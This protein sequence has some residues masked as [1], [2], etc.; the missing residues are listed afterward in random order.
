MTVAE[1][2]TVVLVR[3]GARVCALPIGEVVETMRPQPTVPLAG[4]PPFVK[5]V[6]I[7]RGAPTPVIDLCDLLGETGGTRASRF[8]TVATGGR[9]VALAVEGV[10]GIVELDGSAQSPLPPLLSGIRSSAVESIGAIDRDLLV[11]LEASR[12]VPEDVWRAIAGREVA[13]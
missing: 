8:V 1:R 13:T 11:L 3:A 2:A 6:A 7:I 12:I 10:V 9:V 5:G 4:V